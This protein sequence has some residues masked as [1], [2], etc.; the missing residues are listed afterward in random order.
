M[1]M[2]LKFMADEVSIAVILSIRM[3][4]A[5]SSRKGAVGRQLWMHWKLN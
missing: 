2:L 4:L 1:A 3:A 5:F